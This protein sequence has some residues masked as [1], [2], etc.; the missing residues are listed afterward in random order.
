MG[1]TLASEPDPDRLRALDERLAKLK[2]Q[3]KPKEESAAK[4]FS[5]GEIAWRMVIELCSGLLVGFGIGYGLDYLFGTMPIFLMILTLLGF[6]AGVR[7]MMGTAR[8]MTKDSTVRG[9]APAPERNEGNER[10][11]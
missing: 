3:P 4:G 5:Q 11:G 2:E 7:T 1:V 6:V 10:G 9:D 8:E